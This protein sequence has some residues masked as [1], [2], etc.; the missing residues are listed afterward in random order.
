MT[1]GRRPLYTRSVPRDPADE[2]H[3]AR[4]YGRRQAV[5]RASG[6]AK[7]LALIVAGLLRELKAAGV[8]EPTYRALAQRV[9]ETSDVTRHRAAV[10]EI[11]ALLEAHDEARF[12]ATSG[13]PTGRPEVTATLR[14]KRRGD[15]SE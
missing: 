5:L 6:S 9:K 10:W 2:R 15:S 12:R 7:E 11:I 1:S 3:R 4:K 14:Q 13:R 8:A